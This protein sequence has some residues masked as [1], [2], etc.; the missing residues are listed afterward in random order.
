MAVTPRLQL[1][2]LLRT[3]RIALDSF[4][5]LVATILRTDGYWVHPS[6]KVELTREDKRAIELPSSPRWELDLVAYKGATNEITVVEC[7]SY[8]DQRGVQFSAF[9]HGAK[10]SERFKLFTN[11]KIR[12]MVLTKLREQLETRGLCPPHPNIKLA[13]ATGKIASPLDRTNLRQHFAKFGWLLLDDEWLYENLERLARL[14]Y[15]NDVGVM[16]AKLYSNR[17]ANRPLSNTSE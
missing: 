4:E 6:F 17:T 14:G 16:V 5:S 2:T 10:L 12:E 11:D 9:Q 7:K 1:Q 3:L 13:L 15:E 8:L